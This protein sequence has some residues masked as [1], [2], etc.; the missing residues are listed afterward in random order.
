MSLD[1][2]FLYIFIR[3][4]HHCSHKADDISMLDS[5]CNDCTLLNTD[6]MHAQTGRAKHVDTAGSNFVGRFEKGV[7]FA[8]RKCCQCM[9]SGT[10]KEKK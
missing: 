9:A 8:L 7:V 10:K 4:A 1:Y 5:S 6:V 2:G 3:T